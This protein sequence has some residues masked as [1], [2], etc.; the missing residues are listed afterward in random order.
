M[1]NKQFLVPIDLTKNQILN[2]VLHNLAS[3]PSSPVDGQIYY[4]TTDNTVYFWRV[5]DSP[6]PGDGEWINVAGDISAVIAGNGLSG[7]GTSGSVTLDVNVDNATL[8]IASDSV[9][10]KDSG[11]VT[12]KINDGAVTTAKITDANVTF[13]K[14]QNMATMTLLG[15]VT[16]GS[17]VASEIPI[18]SSTSLTGA[19]N[20]NI[21]T[22]SAVKAYVDANVAALGNLEG[23]FDAATS[24]NFPVG[25]TPTAGTKKGDYWYVTVAGTVHTVPMNIGDVLVAKIDNAG[26]TTAA[27]WIVLEANRYQATTTV[28]GIVMLATSAEVNTGTDADKVVTPSTLS[29]RTATETRTGLAE[30]ATQAETNT[31]SD[32]A[33]IVTP[34]KLKTLLDARVGGYATNLTGSA[35]SYVVTHNL[36]TLDVIIEVYENSTGESVYPGVERTTVNSCTIYFTVAPTTNQYRVVIKK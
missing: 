18:I 21:P 7:G 24:T 26:V 36:N 3:H 33:R 14:I 6:S 34:L 9:R 19:S 11:V 4:N 32:D 20:A 31:G 29:A 8:E 2:V 30:L 17:G 5:T 13:A 12:A 15:R 22:T 25:S 16:A 28:L 23:A 35:T 10:I 1:A 27:D